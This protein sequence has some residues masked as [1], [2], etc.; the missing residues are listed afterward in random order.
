VIDKKTA[1]KLKLKLELFYAYEI[2]KK[3]GTFKNVS[4]LEDMIPAT[5]VTFN[6]L[7]LISVERFCL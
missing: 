4:E 2:E 3:G 7:N 6:D 1:G 5:L